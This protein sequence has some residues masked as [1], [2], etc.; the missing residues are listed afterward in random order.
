MFISRKPRSIWTTLPP[1]KE[2]CISLTG[3]DIPVLTAQSVRAQ[4]KDA[5]HHGADSAT[6]EKKDYPGM[7]WMP[8]KKD[9]GK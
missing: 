8:G 4:V 1:E 3:N 9:Q 5:P 7:Q 2:T 6:G